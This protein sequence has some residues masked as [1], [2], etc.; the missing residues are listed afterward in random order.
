MEKTTVLALDIRHRRIQTVEGRDPV[1][2]LLCEK[3]LKVS[4]VVVS[5]SVVPAN[6]L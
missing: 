3:S 2:R 1:L 4:R 6:L 5:F